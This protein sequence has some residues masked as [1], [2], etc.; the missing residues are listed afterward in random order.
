MVD[1]IPVILRDNVPKLRID[2]YFSLLI[3][4]LL[5]DYIFIAL[6]PVGSYFLF[7]LAIVLSTSS[8][9]TSGGMVIPPAT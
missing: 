4:N 8:T 3:E 9:I 5:G 1:E 2:D 6:I 7:I